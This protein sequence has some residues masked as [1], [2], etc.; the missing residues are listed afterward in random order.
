MTTLVNAHVPIRRRRICRKRPSAHRVGV[1]TNAKFDQPFGIATAGADV[2]VGDAVNHRIR[3]VTPGG[4][5]T[6]VAGDGTGAF[7]DGPAAAARFNTP[8][9]VAVG[10]DGAI[11]VA[12]RD[13][14]RI[15]RVAP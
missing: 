1:G 5:V 6:T 3:R 12:D 4:A 10:G 11:Y 15:R 9:G 7:A 14:K 2:I 13:N 8:R